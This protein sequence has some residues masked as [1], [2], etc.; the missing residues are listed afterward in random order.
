VHSNLPIDKQI[1][2]TG[3]TWLDRQLVAQEASLGTA[4]FGATVKDALRARKEFLVENGLAQRDYHGVRLP[5]NLLAMLR[6]RELESVARTLATDTGLTYRPLS[7]GQS[8]SG[9]YRR[10]IST[11]S[12][13]FAM[14]DDGLGFSLV[15]WRSVLE[16]RL[17]ESMGVTMRGYQLVWS[18]GR[19]R[20]ISR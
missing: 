15:P 19:Q 1:K 4:G 8:A 11:A 3:A 6:E 5:Q 13:R 16:K 7:D 14:L 17:G 12:G 2:A 10:M 20:T 18:F 9:V